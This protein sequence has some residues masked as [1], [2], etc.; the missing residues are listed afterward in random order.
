MVFMNGIIKNMK[1]IGKKVSNMEKVI[2]LIQ[3][4]KEKKV[5]GI[6][7]NVCNG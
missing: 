3:K 1:E 2:L 7:E 6:W 5:N 4:V